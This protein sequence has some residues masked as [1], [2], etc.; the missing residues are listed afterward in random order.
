MNQINHASA[1]ERAEAYIY[2]IPKFTKKNTLDNTKKLLEALGNPSMDKKIIHVAGT[3]GKGSV[4]A[5]L[6]GFLLES[7]KTVGMFTSPHLVRMTERIRLNGIEV[8]KEQFLDVFDHVLQCVEKS[9]ENDAKVNH[10]TFF[11]ILFLIAMVVFQE[12]DVEYIILETG[13]GGRLDSTNVISKP[14]LTIVTRIGLDHCQYLGNTKE[15]IASEKAGIIKPGVP[16]VFLKQEVNVTNVVQE[17]A[18]KMGCFC[19]FVDESTF[20]VEKINKKNI[21]F[22]YESRYYGYISFTVPNVALYQAENIS[23]ALKGLEI[24][25]EPES[26]RP[27]IIQNAILK[28]KWEG[29]MEEIEPG[30]LADGA[31]NEDGIKAF[32]QTVSRLPC[33]GRRWLLFS[34]VD[35]KDDTVMIELLANSQ[36]FDCFAVAALQEERGQSIQILK[37]KFCKCGIENAIYFTDIE[38]AYNFCKDKRQKEDAVYI[39][40]SLYLIGNIKAVLRR[41]NND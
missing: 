24:I 12:A 33:Q 23:L 21:D 27:E 18:K 22:S 28:V 39:A 7:R 36:L 29:R 40:G 8:S 6:N 16:L 38:E 13:L 11:E 25:S 1:Y 30:I 35:D 9:I 37:E 26:C 41:N 19:Y 5:Y 4:C 3:N 2:N 15:E 20:H 14:L 34:V 17:Y 10:P 32:L 31:H